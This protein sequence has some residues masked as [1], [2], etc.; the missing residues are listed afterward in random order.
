MTAVHAKG[1]RWK[2]GRMLEFVEYR[3]FGGRGGNRSDLVEVVGD[4]ALQ[5]QI[6]RN[7]QEFVSVLGLM[8]RLIFHRSQDRTWHIRFALN[9]HLAP[10]QAH[11]LT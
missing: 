4:S 11:D 1:F 3:L 7:F 6:V 5:A 8:G 9:G 10:A 2:L